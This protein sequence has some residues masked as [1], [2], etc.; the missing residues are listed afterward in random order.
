MSD[1]TKKTLKKVV[2]KWYRKMSTWQFVGYIFTPIAVTGEGAIL[3][4]N[5]SPLFHGVVIVAVVIT[6]YVKYMVKDVDGDGYID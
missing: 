1:E 3:A 4:L 6:G 2:P 5:L